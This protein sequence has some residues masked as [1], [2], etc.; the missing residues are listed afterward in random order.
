MVP[1]GYRITYDD[2]LELPSDN[3]PR[4]V[5]GGELYVSPTPVPRHQRLCREIFLLLRAAIAT[6]SGRP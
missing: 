5:I 2:W 6:V 4:E 1:E 3:V